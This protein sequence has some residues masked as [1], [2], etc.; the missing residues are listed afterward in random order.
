[1]KTAILF[2]T[3]I[4]NEDIALQI[5]KL[6]KETDGTA[7][8]HVCLQTDVC[9]TDIPKL[10]RLFTYTL[11]SINELGCNTWENTMPGGNI[12]LIMLRFFRQHPLYDHYWVIEY[13]VRFSGNWKDFFSFF[14]NKG[15][16]FVSAYIETVD[17]NPGWNRWN[18]LELVGIHPD[19]GDLLKSFNPICRL[20]GRAL[21]LLDERCRLGDRGHFEVLLP[22]L[23]K[24]YRLNIADFGGRGRYIYDGHPDLFYM[25]VWDSHEENS[26]THRF[27]PRYTE[28]EMTVPDMIYHP[29]K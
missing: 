20:S 22:T 21:R 23:F 29:V 19:K 15:E 11:E 16:D 12:H 17:D 27:R 26:S 10:P 28:K 14:K 18:E 13:D 7:D 24:Y 4:Y 2:I 1:M 5:E 6:R 9:R 3:H 25:D 8:L